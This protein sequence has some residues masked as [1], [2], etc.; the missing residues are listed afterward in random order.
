MQTTQLTCPH[1]SSTLNFGAAI[2]AGTPVECLICMRAFTAVNPVTAEA[3]P[4]PPGVEK[5]KPASSSEVMIAKPR[6]APSGVTA[7]KS[8]PIGLPTTSTAE[9]PPAPRPSIRQRAEGPNITLIAGTVAVLLLLTGGIGVGLWKV[10]TPLCGPSSGNKDEKIVKVE[11]PNE[12]QKDPENGGGT[13]LNI[14]P[15]DEQ[16]IR[17]K[18]REEI[19]QV[20]KR[21]PRIK[22]DGDDPEWNLGT[23]TLAK[24]AVAGIDQQ[25]INLAIE[26]G[27]AFLKKTQQP[28]GSWSFAQPTGHAAL[29][30]LTLLECGVP[31][32]DKTVQRAATF[33]RSQS[34]SLRMT[35]EM[36]LAVLFLD[37]LGEPRD[38]PLIQ[39]MALR[40]MSGQNDAGGWT[41]VCDAL[42]PQDMLQLFTVLKS[43]EQLLNPV[44]VTPKGYALDPVRDTKLPANDPFRQFNDLMLMQGVEGG[45]PKDDPKVN[46]KTDPKTNPKNPAGPNK[47]DALNQNLKNLPV[48][49]QKAKGKGKIFVRPG[50]GDN[51]NTQFALLAL[52]A[53]RRHGVPTT[54]ALLLANQ[55]FTN[56]QN[57]DNGW[58]YLMQTGSTNTMTCVG[59]LGLGIGH[60]AAPEIVK[61]DPKNPIIKPALE[62]AR[63]QNGLQALA[64]NIGQPSADAKK[65]DFPMENLYFL[66]S[67]ERVAMLYD[68]KTIGGKEWYGWGAQ[69]LVHNQNANGAWQQSHYHGANP[70][71]NTCFA[72]LFLKRSNLV[73]DLTENLRLNVGVRESQ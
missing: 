70:V 12:N 32:D 5:A 54:Q 52:W 50:A 4:P 61:A 33:V 38:R 39:G 7:P 37:R 51:S 46:P 56:S 21:K 31:A 45:K 67:V 55:R 59:L 1:C 9:T 22:I 26:R 15:D 28:N 17:A 3:V 23:T 49:Q 8:A 62:D 47:G 10:T 66:W 41:Y 44:G 29:G 71:L 24:N 60:G 48:V 35:Y 36:S 42:S 14:N 18:L 72:M 19:K 57:A 13:P 40:L 65:R 64:R 73:A 2:S 58:G 53:A 6:T 63:I 30:G 34:A 25:M 11:L 16:D 27:V 20:L 68:L 69:I 43:N